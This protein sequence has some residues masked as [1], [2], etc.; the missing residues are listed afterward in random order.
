M[1]HAGPLW[2]AVVF[3]DGQCPLCS[4]EV[5]VYRR[6]D[7]ENHLR[8]VDIA[9]PGFDAV[10]HGLDPLRVQEVMHVQTA[11]GVVHT[12][13][14]AFIVIWQALPPSLLTRTAIMVLRAPGM[15]M[16]AGV[17]Y[18][19]FARNRYRLTG[20]CTPTSCR[21]RHAKRGDRGSGDAQAD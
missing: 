8:F 15:M 17:L 13:V 11:N 3:Y 21:P 19:A 9:A 10:R 4:R 12:E 6:R 16:L 1:K 5:A 14:E 2:P 18:R 20:R 7:R